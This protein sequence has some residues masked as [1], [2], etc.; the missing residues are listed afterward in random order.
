M[1][2]PPTSRI[3]FIDEQ[4]N[5]V[6]APK[7][8]QKATIE[9]SMVVPD[10]VTFRLVISERL[11]NVGKDLP[12]KIVLSK[13]EHK[14]VMASDWERAGPGHYSLKLLQ[15]QSD[16]SWIEIEEYA[17]TISS[18]IGKDAVQWLIDDVDF[19]LPAGIAISMQMM[20]A[21]AKLKLL[22]PGQNTLNQ[23]IQ[24]LR[25]SIHGNTSFPGLLRLL[26]EVKKHVRERVEPFEALTR[27]DRSRRPKIDKLFQSLLIPGNLDKRRNL[28]LV[29]ES[30][31]LVSFDT[32]EN[33][34]LKSYLTEVTLRLNRLGRCLPASERSRIDK[35]LGEPF[36][37]LVVGLDFLKDVRELSQ[38]GNGLS[39]TMSLIKITPYK[40]VLKGFLEL[41]KSYS[42]IMKDHALDA[43][44]EKLP[45]LYQEWCI[46]I[47]VYSLCRSAAL[48][49]YVIERNGIVRKTPNE[50]FVEILP[51]GDPILVLF[52]QSNGKRVSLTLERYFGITGEFRSVTF[53]QRPDF[54]LEVTEGKDIIGLYI[55]D[56]KYKLDSEGDAGTLLESRPKKTDIDKMHSYRD[57]IRV[58]GGRH[59]VKYSSIMY[60][61][62]GY[63]FNFAG[64]EAISACPIYNTGKS[65]HYTDDLDYKLETLWNEI[66]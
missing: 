66:L 13:V 56:P 65:P 23:E 25:D 50:L 60:P 58:S 26:P 27:Q 40:L 39:L 7:D 19:Y 47:L 51:G 14:A 21:F 59:I 44:L 30:R 24:R 17:F 43:P 5:V 29:F 52:N 61:G 4:G 62:P 3:H 41:H 22:P 46:L 10:L 42:A 15:R 54:T 31:Y 35:E 36:R 37:K 11:G 18:K 28:S 33:R 63:D 9:I 6:A 8:W 55:F 32:Y 1:G 20:G 64:V 16:K 45:F 57:S 12:L 49:S 53:P 2:L 34:I 38:Y 48:K